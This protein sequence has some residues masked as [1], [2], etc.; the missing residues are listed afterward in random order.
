MSAIRYD[1]GADGVV[2]LTLDAPASSVNTL[3]SGYRDAMDASLDRLE[4][5]IEDVKGVIVTSAKQT[6][7][8]GGNLGEL[9]GI[10]SD[11]GQQCFELIEKLKGQLR[12]LETLG[13]PV[14]AAI[15]GTAM[16]GG[17]ELALACHR[18][19]AID[20]S[21]VTL[22][23]PEVTLGLLPGAGGIVRTVRLLGLERAF[24]YLVEGKEFRPRQ[25]VEAGLIHELAS[26][27]DD[28]M[29]K[30]RAWILSGPPSVQPWDCKGYEI[31]GGTPANPRIAQ[32]VFVAP[33]MVFEKTKGCY[34]APRAILAAI[35]EGALVDFDTA[36]RIESRYFV[37]LAT[38]QVAK[39]M[40]GTLWFQMN[41]AKSGKSRP[42]GFPARTFRTVGLLG[43]GMMGSGIAHACATAGIDVVLEDM[44]IE[45][46]EAGKAHSRKLLS[47]KVAQGYLS[48]E[49]M[50]ETL[51]RIKPTAC[52]GDLAGC[53]LVIEAVF[54]DRGLKAQ[55][56]GETE[57]C[58]SEATIFASNT[59]TLPITGLALASRRPDRFIGLHFFSPVDRM[60]LVEIIVG[61]K[62]SRETLAQAID[63]VM[64]I[65][66]IPIVVNDSR[67]FFTS[68]VFGTFVNEGMAMLGE[69]ID[70]SV[71]EQAAI[72]AGMPVG[73]LAVSDEVT[74]SLI[75]HIR[76]QT[77][78]D[79][80]AANQPYVP[81]PAEAVLD[82]MVG[83]FG[84]KGR[85]SGAGFYE[86]P[87]DGKKFLWPGLRE[88]FARP[89]PGLP[90]KEVQDRLLFVQV[91]ESI[92]CLEEGVL[93][94]VQDAN[95]GSIL[96]LGFAPWSGGVLQYANQYG[97]REFEARARELA[98]AYGARFEPPRL[99]VEKAG[100][101]ELFRDAAR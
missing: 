9:V 93:T 6:F 90:L 88:H 3:D 1:K 63:F 8:V 37:S 26:D 43:A 82:R 20:D 83:T 70:P 27:A 7:C 42:A 53:D 65:K 61:E 97:I 54:E 35:V 46:A 34:P 17:W 71:I 62:T 79:L 29:K 11:Q 78:A 80:E 77:R 60:K 38:G 23:S 58:T 72:Q 2:V 25:G 76:D 18:R 10:G 67:G 51:R 74:L 5:E 81:H 96:G 99:L 59:S 44:T 16:G 92:R 12:R 24:P 101:N 95:V 39:N 4:A 64:Q 52:I 31:P 98:R 47:K 86:Y 14:V 50:A 87:R 41:A 32:M 49:R 21:R 56:T 15:N 19:L 91:V 89:D 66:K 30:A 73:P 94:N 36:L 75:A 68:R 84:R 33:G 28:L 45:R 69:G 13:K 22:G 55:V 40:I 57:A 85:A 48:E 100:R